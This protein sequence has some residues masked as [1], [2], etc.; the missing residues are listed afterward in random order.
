MDTVVSLMGPPPKRVP[1]YVALAL[2]SQDYPLGHHVEITITDA[3]WLDRL[4]YNFVCL[5]SSKLRVLVSIY[6]KR[7]HCS[8]TTYIFPS[9]TSRMLPSSALL[10]LLLLAVSAVNATPINP[11]SQTL[12]LTSKI[13]PI[14][15]AT[16]IRELDRTRIA[17]LIA[18]ANASAKGKRAVDLVP[19]SNEFSGFTASVGVGNPPTQCE[20][21]DS[22][23]GTALDTFNAC[24]TRQ[25]VDRYWKLKYV[26]RCWGF[27]I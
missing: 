3:V 24:H 23:V 7:R 15:G 9:S 14:Q 10:S 11:A 19:V 25:F 27:E 8:S 5:G 22:I 4:F 2:G 16:T 21:G 1:N 12:A 26:D 18:N 17:A 13:N 6:L 20:S